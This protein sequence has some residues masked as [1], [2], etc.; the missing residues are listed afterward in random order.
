MNEV[1]KFIKI[2]LISA[3]IGAVAG[4]SFGCFVQ[5]KMKKAKAMR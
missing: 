3:S 5:A 1:K 4:L 2:T